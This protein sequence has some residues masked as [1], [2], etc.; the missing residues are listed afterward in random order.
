MQGLSLELFLMNIQNNK[1]PIIDDP[2]FK[3]NTQSFIWQPPIN[4]LIE[5]IVFNEKD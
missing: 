3:L 5:Q 4:N 1:K 2:L